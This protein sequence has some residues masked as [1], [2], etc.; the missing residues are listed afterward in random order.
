[1]SASE[2][3]NDEVIRPPMAEE[4]FGGN[5]RDLIGWNATLLAV[6]CITF[7]LFHLYVLNVY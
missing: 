1:M 5:K 3:T 6:L 4:E 2:P 7:T